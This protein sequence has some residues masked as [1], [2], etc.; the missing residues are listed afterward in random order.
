MHTFSIDAYQMRSNASQY[1]SQLRGLQIDRV[2][3][4]HLDDGFFPFIL[5]TYTG[6]YQLDIE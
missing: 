6:T 3:D 1:N 4:F 2:N 5:A